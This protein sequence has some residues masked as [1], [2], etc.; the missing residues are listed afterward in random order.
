MIGWYH[1]GPKLRSSDLEI[2]ELMKR[3]TP[4]SV[5]VIIDPKRQ[6]VGLPTD[7]YVAVEEIKDDGTATQKTFMH[8]PTIIEAE[9][10]EE[11]EVWAN[12]AIARDGKDDGDASDAEEK[13]KVKQ[14]KR[15]R[16]GAT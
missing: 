5:M 12:M 7:A 11:E 16:S 6:D 9:E 2:N 13:P 3:F 14:A 8:V 1:T 4:R 15:R 10:A